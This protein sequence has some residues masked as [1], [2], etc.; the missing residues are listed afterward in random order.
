MHPRQPRPSIKHPNP[1]P[2]HHK[3]HQ[4]RIIHRQHSRENP[5]DN[6]RISANLHPLEQIQPKSETN[7]ALAQALRD[8]QFRGISGVGVD[9]VGQ[10]EREVEVGRPVDHGDAGE[11]ADPVQFEVGGEAVED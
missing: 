2:P 10:R 6:H 1:L 3:R 9:G 7:P 11:V 4:R 8:D 5:R